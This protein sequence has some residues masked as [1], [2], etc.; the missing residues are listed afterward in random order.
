MLERERCGGVIR[1]C[2]P[3]LFPIVFGD[4]FG[5]IFGDVFGDVLETV[6]IPLLPVAIFVFTSCL[7]HTQKK[8]HKNFTKDPLEESGLKTPKLA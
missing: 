6:R 4:I 3:W 7:T 5:D 1:S 2:I 8:Q